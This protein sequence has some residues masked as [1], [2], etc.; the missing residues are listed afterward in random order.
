VEALRE[1]ESASFAMSDGESPI[2]S[3]RKIW[4][5]DGQFETNG[6]QNPEE[7]G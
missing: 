5:Y 2:S 4:R 6:I 1:T 7:K 3:L